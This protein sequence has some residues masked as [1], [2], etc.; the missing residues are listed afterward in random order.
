MAGV[1][2][3]ENYTNPNFNRRTNPEK[4]FANWLVNK[5]IVKD[6][7]TAEYVM[8]AMAVA[9]FVLSFIIGF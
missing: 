2:F 8:I 4:G 5:G 3:D 7:K 1:Q 9:F 6:K